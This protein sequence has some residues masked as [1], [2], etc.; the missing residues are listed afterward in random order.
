M[1]GLG[2]PVFHDTTQ[3]KDEGSEGGGCRAREVS[4]FLPR[5]RVKEFVDSGRSPFQGGS[6]EPRWGDSGP[7]LDRAQ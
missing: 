7:G 6:S 2:S 4:E 1:E 3:R 5:Y